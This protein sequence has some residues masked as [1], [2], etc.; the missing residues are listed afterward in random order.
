MKQPKDLKRAIYKGEIVTLVKSG[1]GAFLYKDW[2]PVKENNKNVKLDGIELEKIK[3]A[4]WILHQNDYTQE[5]QDKVKKANKRT[6]LENI[7]NFATAARQNDA[8]T[9]A[10]DKRNAVFNAI[11]DKDIAALKYAVLMPGFI[12]EQLIPDTVAKAI[13]FMQKHPDSVAKSKEIA[14]LANTDLEEAYKQ[15]QIYFKIGIYKIHKD[16]LPG[17]IA[18]LNKEHGVVS[19]EDEFLSNKE[20]MP[21]SDLLQTVKEKYAVAIKEYQKFNTDKNYQATYDYFLEILDHRMIQKLYYGNTLTEFTAKDTINYEGKDI[22]L[23]DDSELAKWG[24][25]AYRMQIEANRTKRKPQ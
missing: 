10:D 9:K 14:E 4:Y 15:F 2:K 20:N 21:N 6:M 16:N 7:E 18:K 25:Y 23:K 11:S 5:K 24:A 13:E 17:S 8:I 3:Q 22:E 19:N 1:T 12:E